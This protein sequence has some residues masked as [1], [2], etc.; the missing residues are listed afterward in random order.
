MV[1]SVLLLV[2][3][4]YLKLS[5]VQFTGIFKVPPLSSTS[6]GLHGILFKEVGYFAALNWSAYGIFVTPFLVWCGLSIWNDIQESFVRIAEY[7][8]IRDKNFRVVQARALA[9][10]WQRRLRLYRYLF[11][12]LAIAGTIFVMSNW[13]TAVA[14]PIL[15][16]AS[17]QNVPVN[18]PDFEYDWSISWLYANAHVGRL[19]LLLFTFLAY[20]CIPLVST[21]L[22]LE[23]LAVSFVYVTFL[24]S[25]GVREREWNVS[26]SPQSEESRRRGGWEVFAGFY[27]HLLVFGLLVMAGLWLMITQ[28]TYLRDSGS[29]N[30][31]NFLFNVSIKKQEVNILNPIELM[32]FI[33][34]VANW[35]I[36]YNP[37]MYMGL[38]ID[39]GIILFGLVCYISI[40]GSIFLLRRSAKV[41]VKFAKRH[42]KELAE[43]SRLTQREVRER[44]RKIR[45]WPIAWMKEI[46]LQLIMFFFLLSL[47]Y[48]RAILLVGIVAL[49]ILAKRMF[50]VAGNFFSGKEDEEDDAD[51]EE[52]E[53]EKN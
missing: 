27:T 50:E 44:L 24:S 14:T 1:I 13:W 46:Q 30:I 53:D 26:A 28:N 38:K 19:P 6:I 39:V 36:G 34:L 10:H 21:L 49:Y 41:S 47:F 17:I 5:S 3:A 18:N 52:D 7:G 31:V 43:E 20:A 51:E 16:P 37:H 15:S 8:L 11:F 48:C 22:T 29:D 32:D 12:T 23:T 42:A 4:S 35:V 45:F 2:A 40:I 25:W 9:A 33:G